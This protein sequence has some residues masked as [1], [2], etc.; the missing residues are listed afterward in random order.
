MQ[1]NFRGKRK[2][3]ELLETAMMPSAQNH[4]TF[5]FKILKNWPDIVGESLAKNSTPAKLIFPSNES[6]RGVL[7]IMV[8]NPGF[9]LELQA[10]E[11]FIIQ[12]ISTY[13]GY[14]AVDRI[15]VEISRQRKK[16]ATP[17]VDQPADKIKISHDD[18]QMIVTSIHKIKDDK[19]RE[20]L[21]EI[22]DNSFG[23]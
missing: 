3:A 19:L 13:F 9:S 14:Q 15:K 10:R 20:L 7:Q 8:E 21:E 16:I 12:R 2:L 4:S 18:R 1:N 23:S 22:I 5:M 6:R 17:A 11:R